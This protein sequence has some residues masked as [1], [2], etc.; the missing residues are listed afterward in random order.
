VF[1]PAASAVPLAVPLGV[2]LSIP[3]LG[4]LVR[5]SRQV[6]RRHVTFG[7]SFRNEQVK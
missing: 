2:P 7:Y 4:S 6:I 3:S 1:V 5:S